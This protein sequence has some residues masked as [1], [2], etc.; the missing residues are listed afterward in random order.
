MYLGGKLIYQCAGFVKAVPTVDK[1]T[2]STTTAFVCVVVCTF[3]TFNNIMRFCEV[4]TI[5]QSTHIFHSSVYLQDNSRVENVD[6][7]LKIAQENILQKIL[8]GHIA[9]NSHSYLQSECIFNF[10]R[11]PNFQCLAKTQILLEHILVE[12]TA[13][14]LQHI[15]AV[16][17]LWGKIA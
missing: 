10:M 1:N 16:R 14:N 9:G 11:S 7:S 5:V 4:A 15:T 8:L 17:E 12:I 13:E 6:N 2:E 3:G